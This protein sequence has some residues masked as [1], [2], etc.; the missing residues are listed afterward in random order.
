MKKILLVGKLNEIV[1]SLYQCLTND[2][3]VQ[4]CPE[5]PDDIKNMYQIVKPDM[6]IV[7][8]I[9][10]DEVDTTM[11]EWIR[12]NT[13]DTPVLIITISEKW[14]E[15]EPYFDEDKFDKLFRPVGK[16]ELL[17]K[18]HFMLKDDGK[19]VD[20]D[21]IRVRRKIMIV[22][23]SAML[24]RSVKA[25][26]DKEYTVYVATSGEQ[27]LTMVSKRQPDLILL[28]YEMPGM[29][30]K[31][32]Y[33]ILK[34][35][36]ETKDIPVVFLTSMSDKEHIYSILETRPAGYI[37]KPPDRDRL[38]QTIEDVLKNIDDTREE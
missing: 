31:M 15:Y 17:E 32:T 33:E 23:D 20:N 11:C 35:Q 22:D 10:V 16:R 25:S 21:K 2:F 3:Q 9:G 26:L 7:S 12:D 29:D 27:A 24:L 5:E 14:N 6:M 28:D 8:Q 1:R 36:D 13:L 4:L 18:C 37:L 38:F 30:G 34:S 19:N